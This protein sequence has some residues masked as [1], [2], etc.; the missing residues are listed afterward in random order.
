[1]ISKQLCSS[2]IPAV[3]SSESGSDAL[4]YMDEYKTS[5]LPVLSDQ[6]YL[7]LISEPDIFSLVDPDT[8][9][10]EQKV[11][12]RMVYVN[13]NQHA[14]D[15]IKIMTTEKITLLPVLDEKRNYLGCITLGN[16]TEL[17]GKFSAFESPGAVLILELNQNDYVLSQIA[18]IVESQ[19]A[20][21]LSLYVSSDKDST[22]ME[23]TI[24]VNTMEI[25]S[26]IKTLNRY[27]YI[28]KETF[29]ENEDTYNDL[30]DRYNALMNYLNI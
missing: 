4:Y 3:K 11:T 8:P 7:G 6:Q 18:Q 13:E 21:I 12:Y 27:N 9:L 24:K 16:L 22:K 29:T 26:L 17:F 10:C 30:L 5:F 23:I 25:Q 19:D 2:A 1:M 28:I 15:A 20:K 14:F